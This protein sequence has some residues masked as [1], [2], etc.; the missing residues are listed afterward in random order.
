[1]GSENPEAMKIGW[2]E[3]KNALSEIVQV[4]AAYPTKLLVW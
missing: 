2:D 3:G 4:N 1:M